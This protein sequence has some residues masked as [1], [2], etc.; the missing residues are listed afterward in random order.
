[1]KTNEKPKKFDLEERT[2]RFADETRQLIRS[3]PKNSVEPGDRDQLSRSSGL[4][5]A[6]YMEA[7]EALSAKDFIMRIK[8]CRKEARESQLWLKLLKNQTELIFQNE[9]TK[10]SDEANQL[11]KIFNSIVFKFKD[12]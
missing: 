8:I 2:F 9:I 11:V 4:V 12:K 10:L 1:M 5:A 3:L 6:N 7:N